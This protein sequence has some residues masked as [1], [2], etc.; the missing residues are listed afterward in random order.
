[1]TRCVILFNV[2]LRRM[3]LE[4][5]IIEKIEADFS[6]SDAAVAVRLLY[7]A[8]KTGRLARCIVV[9]ASGKIN[10]L[11]GYIQ[12]SQRDFRDVIVAGEYDQGLRHVRDLRASFM[13]DAPEKWWIADIAALLQARGYVLKSLRCRRATVG[14]FDF[15]ADEGEGVAEFCGSPNPITIEKLNRRWMLHGDPATLARYGLNRPFDD[16]RAFADAISCFILA[17]QKPRH[18]VD[19][20]DGEARYTS[21]SPNDN[22]R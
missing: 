11:R 19:S 1:M 7:D 16:E 15:T 12:L 10:A 13:I 4:Q 14:P 2:G 17:T 21:P 6:A 18:R 3:P 8:G 20:T 5:D 9:A 22:G